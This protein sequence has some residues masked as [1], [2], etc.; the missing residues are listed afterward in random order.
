[1]MTAI[2]QCP[3][4]ACGRFSHLGED[5]LGRIF[6]CPHCLT[7][8]PTAAAAAAD[9]RWTA[10]F[11]GPRTGAA[12][13]GA[14]SPQSWGWAQSTLTAVS[15]RRTVSTLDTDSGEVLISAMD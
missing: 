10:V 13:L 14:K 5:P 9:S 15:A 6:R 7:K 3:N 1:M 8:L 12:R 4:G 11:W 2:M